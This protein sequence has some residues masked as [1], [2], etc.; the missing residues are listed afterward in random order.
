MRPNFKR[1][2]FWSDTHA[3]RRSL[4][5]TSSPQNY[6][7]LLVKTSTKRALKMTLHRRPT[8]GCRPRKTHSHSILS[9]FHLSRSLARGHLSLTAPRAR[10]RKGGRNEKR[11]GEG[12]EGHSAPAVGAAKSQRQRRRRMSACV[13]RGSC[14]RP[15]CPLLERD[16]SNPQ[17][18]CQPGVLVHL[19]IG[20]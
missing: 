5:H 8:F 17:L 14:A 9:S 20:Q 13:V 3:A 6:S 4:A 16:L 19:V 1:L 12:E 7:S 10:L 11:S 18:L 2:L 15:Q